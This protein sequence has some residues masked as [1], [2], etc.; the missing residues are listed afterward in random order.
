MEVSIRIC[1]I[2]RGNMAYARNYGVEP[3]SQ[4]LRRRSW[5]NGTS[6]EYTDVCLLFPAQRIMNLHFYVF[7]HLLMVN[8]HSTNITFNWF[9]CVIW[10]NLLWISSQKLFICTR[11]MFVL[12]LIG[13]DLLVTFL[14]SWFLNAVLMKSPFYLRVWYKRILLDCPLFG[15][16]SFCN[17]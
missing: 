10:F 1:F 7:G 5:G 12:I 2:C 15:S 9:S 16:S 17:F 3:R 11:A 6:C 8:I 14:L 4:W 13:Y